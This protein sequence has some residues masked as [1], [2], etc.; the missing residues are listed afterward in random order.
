MHTSALDLAIICAYLVAVLIIGVVLSKRAS[1]SMDSYFLGGKT[2]PWYLLGLSNASGMFDVSGTMW[3][4]YL[5]FAYGLK[6]VWVPWLWPVFNQ[7]FL[8]VYLSV[9]LRRSNVLTGAEWIATRFG[10]DRG[11]RLSH[12][13]IVV[14]AVVGVL[15]FL[16][17]GFIGIGKFIAIFM[18]PEWGISEHAYGIIFTGIATVYVVLGGMY[19]IVLTDL[20]QFTIMTVSAVVIAVIAM[21]QVSPEALAAVTPATWHT[22]W[23]GWKLDLD[24]AALVPSW[25]T[26]VMTQLGAK[27]D[28]DGYGLF[29]AFVMMMLFKG[30]LVSAAGPA[31]NYDMQKILSTRR[32]KD[33]A[34]M[35]GFVS[36]V[37]M[38]SRYLMIAGF[39]VLALVLL[40][41]DLNAVAGTID[42]ENVLPRAIERFVPPGLLG[43]LLAGLL[44]AFMSTFAA[45]VNAAPAYIVNDLYKRYFNPGASNRTLMRASYGVSFG[46]VVVS[47]LIGFVIEDINQILNWIVSALWGGYVAAN[48]LKWYWWRLNG[49]GYFWGMVSGILVSIVPIALQT[50]NPG[51]Y[52]DTLSLYYFPVLLVVS[53]VGCVA[54][55]L[56]TPPDDRAVLKSFYRTVRPWGFW[57]PIRDEVMAEDP[58]FRPNP[59]FG[60]DMVNVAVGIVWQTTLVLLPIYVIVRQGTNLLTTAAILLITTLILK[61]NWYDKLN[62][63]EEAH[64]LQRATTSR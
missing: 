57:G 23:F 15:G 16:S 1:K 25:N 58:T 56:L 9:W 33:A 7:I 53:T 37:L 4:V 50:L 22:P 38:P 55:S 34:L 11:G 3:M 43:L 40:R 45:T 14:F 51:Q 41:G 6:S 59:N 52:P 31:P 63:D 13:V 29:G 8:M 42:F 61:K 30:I 32:P 46:V 5:F 27:I 44:A 21:T 20:L 26:N 12:M 36:V 47:T 28:R 54:G 35:S 49:Y 62:Q 24:W 2:L 10:T 19:S 64:E 39:G 60:R 48:V 18:P 17:Y